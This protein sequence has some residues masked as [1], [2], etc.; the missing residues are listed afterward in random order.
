LGAGALKE[1]ALAFHPQV[2]LRDDQ[3]DDALMLQ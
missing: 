3:G 2:Q 1:A